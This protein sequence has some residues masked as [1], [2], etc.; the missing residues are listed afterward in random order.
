MLKDR[1]LTMSIK[2]LKRCEILAMADEKR[3]TQHD[4]AKRTGVTERHYRRL[5]H[6][7]R[8]YGERRIISGH[9]EKISGNRMSKEKKR[10][11]PE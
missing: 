3:I 1:T 7:Y 2:E 9:R 11:Y 8:E 6:N 4:G 10:K 5:L